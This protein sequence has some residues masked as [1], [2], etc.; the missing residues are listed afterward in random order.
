VADQ[1]GTDE[2][3]AA[4]DHNGPAIHD[5]PASILLARLTAS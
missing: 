5:I 2:T 4:R 3:G 1:R